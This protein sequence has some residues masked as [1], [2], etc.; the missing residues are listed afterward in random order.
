VRRVTSY[1]LWWFALF[2]LFLLYQGDLS[3]IDVI[4]AACA[5][6]LGAAAAE[7]ARTVSAPGVRIEPRWVA[8]AWSVPWQ[9]VGE[10]GLLTWALVARRGRPGRF[11]T[12]PFPGRGGGPATRGR[13]AFIAFAVTL[14][15]N[16]YVVD[17]D[18]EQG[19]AFVHELVPRAGEE[20]L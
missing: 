13:R 2:W 16:S 17:V 1:A 12:V 3:R 10:F 7:V 6:T 9:V 5:A 4:A 11:R 15:P 20:L 14:S 18:E 19:T 8:R